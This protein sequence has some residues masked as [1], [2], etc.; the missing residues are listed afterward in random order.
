MKKRN[1]RVCVELQKSEY[2]G[3]MH[4]KYT[5]YVRILNAASIPARQIKII[6]TSEKKPGM[7]TVRIEITE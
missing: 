3:I 7:V 6:E 5:E 2:N 1:R 4:D